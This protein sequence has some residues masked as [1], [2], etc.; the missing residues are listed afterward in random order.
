MAARVRMSEKEAIARGLIEGPPVTVPQ[1]SKV[2][3]VPVFVK[4]RSGLNFGHAMAV[5]VGFLVGF[6]MGLAAH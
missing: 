6:I 5:V 2:L 3:H 4:E 1:V